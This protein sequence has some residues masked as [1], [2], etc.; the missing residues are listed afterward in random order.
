MVLV[1]LEE[2]RS[3]FCKHSDYV[4][5]GEWEAEIEEEEGNDLNLQKKGRKSELHLEA[6]QALMLADA[7]ELVPLKLVVVGCRRRRSM[8]PEH[9]CFNA[10]RL[11][12][13]DNGSAVHAQVKMPLDMNSC[14]II[15]RS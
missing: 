7:L 6:G 3:S 10:P 11:Y 15:T 14:L 12:D 4:T 13:N 2:E 8:D 5:K 1:E 9:S